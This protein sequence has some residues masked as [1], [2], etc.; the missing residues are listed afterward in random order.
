MSRAKER[1]VQ[2]KAEVKAKQAQMFGA[3]FGKPKEPATTKKAAIA[4][5]AA[6]NSPGPSSE[7]LVGPC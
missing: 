5:P 4:E 1:E 6:D 2:K 3:F 7:C